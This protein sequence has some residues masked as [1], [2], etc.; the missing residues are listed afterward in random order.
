MREKGPGINPG[1]F[2]VGAKA[3][4]AGRQRRMVIL[5][6]SNSFRPGPRTRRA[7]T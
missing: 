1:A 6:F 4:G 2:F 5:R 7:A 3:A